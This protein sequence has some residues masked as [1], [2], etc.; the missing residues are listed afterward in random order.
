MVING[1]NFKPDTLKPKEMVSLLLDDE[2]IEM[3]CKK[4]CNKTRLNL[5]LASLCRNSIMHT[6]NLFHYS[7]ILDRQKTEERRM[8]EDSSVK[9][10]KERERKLKQMAVAACG[11]ENSIKSSFDDR[12]ESFVELCPVQSPAQSD[13]SY[14]SET[15]KA[16]DVLDDSSNEGAN[17]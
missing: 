10:V 12:S 8:M 6:Q 7:S 13:K 17:G 3:K 5:N 9:S 15:T 11:K 2:E 1:D 14:F 16:C 4:N